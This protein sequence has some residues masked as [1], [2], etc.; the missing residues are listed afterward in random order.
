MRKFKRVVAF[1][2]IVLILQPLLTLNFSFGADN[3]F[4]RP[5]SN[6]NATNPSN[7]F[8][9][10]AAPIGAGFSI[11]IS[12]LNYILTQIKIAEAHAAKAGLNNVISPTKT[13]GVSLNTSESTPVLVPASTLPTDVSDPRLP[14]GL[15]Q[16]DG[17][18]NNI[19]NGISIWNGYKYTRV[20]T[21]GATGSLSANPTWGASDQTC[22][23]S[24]KSSFL[25]E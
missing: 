20:D 24:T 7:G 22:P 10:S 14:S 17:Q 18:N 21:V 12:D 8:S 23:R 2:S 13:N 3:N 6:G 15:R 11:N 5:I 25:P 4:I 9:T 16:V 1:F 19:S